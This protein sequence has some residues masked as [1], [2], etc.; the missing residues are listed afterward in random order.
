[1]E[2]LNFRDYYLRPLHHLGAVGY[3]N[4]SVLLST[5]AEFNIAQKFARSRK[6]SS[7]IIFV[8]WVN[9]NAR[10]RGLDEKL[11]DINKTAHPTYKKSFYPQQNEVTLRG[12]ILPHFLIGYIKENGE[13]ELNPNLFATEKDFRRILA[14]GFDIDQRNFVNRL[15]E[16]DYTVYFTVDPF[17]NVWDSIE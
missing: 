9:I 2:K 16:T 7:S 4:N 15:K 11:I 17:G 1:V 5:T 3:Y 8:S 6:T 13:M 10:Y 12:G 14:E